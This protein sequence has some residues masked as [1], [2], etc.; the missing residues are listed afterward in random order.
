METSTSGSASALESS[1]FTA[2]NSTPVSLLHKAAVHISN[3]YAHH[4]QHAGEN[5]SSREYVI[6]CWCTVRPRSSSCR[7]ALPVEGQ[8][9]PMIALLRQAKPVRF[10]Q[11]TAKTLSRQ[12][13]KAQKDEGVE[14][15]KLKK[16]TLAFAQ[17]YSSL[18][19]AIGV[20]ARKQRWR[21]DLRR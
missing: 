11:F 10:H 4:T 9:H 16:V 14:K 2:S 18:S 21:A 1:Q 15:S 19:S 20:A 7:N 6:D 12:A 17:R 5:E 3:P 8:S 13:K